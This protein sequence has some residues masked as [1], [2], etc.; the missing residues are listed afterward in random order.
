MINNL[1]ITIIMKKL[2]FFSIFLSGILGA[3]NYLNLNAYA[4]PD[5]NV[6]G[7]QSNIT[8]P[9]VKTINDPTKVEVFVALDHTWCGD[10]T[11]ALVTPGSSGTG[12]VALIKRLGSTADG[13]VGSNVNF[14]A[15]EILSF[16]STA[17]EFMVPGGGGT[18]S[19]IKTGTYRPTAGLNSIPVAYTVADLTA[20]FTNLS[21]NGTWSLKVFDSSSGDTGNLINWGIEFKAGT[22]LGIDTEIISTP[23]LSVL[24][25]PFTETLNLKINNAAR[26]VQFDIYSMEGKKVYSY[27][28]NGSKNANGDLKIPTDKWNSGIYILSPT[29]N[30]EKLMSIKL[31]KK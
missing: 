4:I 2:L 17:T 20:M 25:N 1:L 12:P 31:M 11:V 26:D 19:Y 13:S 22:F 29:V 3:Q 21:V 8:V 14:K 6:N 10:L 24:G 15:S 23:G 16:N 5:S 27:Q 30:G 7:V 28:Q 9:L 18:D